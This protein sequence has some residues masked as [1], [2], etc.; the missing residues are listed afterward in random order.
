MYREDAKEFHNRL[1][2]DYPVD[3]NDPDYEFT[4]FYENW[5]YGEVIG[6]CDLTEK[7][8]TL[9]MLAAC[10]GTLSLDEFSFLIPSAINSFGLKP[11]EIKE[12]VYQA[13]AYLGIARVFPFLQKTNEV[14]KSL[15][16]TESKEPRNTISYEERKLSGNEKQVEIFGEVMRGYYNGSKFNE[17]SSSNCFGDYYTRKGLQLRERELITFC[18]LISQGGCE[19]QVRGHT[20]GNIHVGNSA[21]YLIETATQL[22]PYIGYPRVTNAIETVKAVAETLKN[23]AE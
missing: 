14:F 4:E 19:A 10:M 11:E 9:A 1:F 18:F 15:N 2:P 20:I 12:L 23:T 16:I 21:E 22:L 13:T 17:W 3:E 5:A 7:D 8:R 6:N